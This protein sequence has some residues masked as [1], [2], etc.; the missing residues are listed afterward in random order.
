MNFTANVSTFGVHGPNSNRS[1]AWRLLMNRRPWILG[2]RSS[3]KPRDCAE[4]G[5]GAS[6]QYHKPLTTVP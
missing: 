2:Y 5:K 6:K 1:S 3:G 4:F